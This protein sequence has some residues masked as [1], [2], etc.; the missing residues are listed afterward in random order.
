MNKALFNY[1][2]SVLVGIIDGI[3]VPLTVYCFFTGLGKSP[4]QVGNNTLYVALC[5]AFLLAIGGFFTRREELSHTHEKRIL[6]VYRGLDVADHIKE[7]LIKDAQRENEEWKNEWQQNA[8]AVEPLPPLSYAGAI[9]TGYIIGSLVV[10][11]NARYFRLPELSF[12]MIPTAVL[13]ITGFY[14]YRLFGRPV[15]GG[16]F[17]TAGGG[18]AAAMGAYWIAH[19]FA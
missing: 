14:K 15:I 1:S 5:A 10:L 17:L 3:I 2:S 18:L 16:M 11:A 8:L 19:L 4:Q 7:D 9:F 13:L 6:K 12:F